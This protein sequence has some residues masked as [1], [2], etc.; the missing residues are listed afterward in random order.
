MRA[1]RLG[2][3]CSILL[4]LV[5]AAAVVRAEEPAGK[6]VRMAFV[7]TVSQASISPGYTIDFW[8]RL[9]ELGWVRGKN[10]IVEELWAEG[11]LERMPALMAQVVEHK[12]DLIVT[13]T[14]VGAIAA[15]NATQTI[16]I[17][18]VA[19]AD[20]V[21]AG[22]AASLSRP[23][24]NLTGLS[25]LSGEGIPGK[26]LELLRE[27]VPRMSVVAVLWN[28]DFPLI[29]LQV[30]HLEADA[31]AQGIKLRLIAVRTQ[32]ALQGAFALAKAHAQAV[33]VI[34]DPLMYSHRPQ[35]TSLAAHHH[36]PAIYTNPE[37]VPDG[38]L[39]A[40]GADLRV[41]YRRAAEYVDKILRGTKPADLPIEEPT[42]YSLVVNL[43]AAQALKLTIPESILLR[44]DEVI[45]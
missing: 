5:A 9:R 8:E 22:V 1:C 35:I 41:V 10:L 15:R 29:Q 42:K 14:E 38:G 11:Q 34:P 45:R 28:P 40:Y 4:I 24:G 17:V 20:P 36:L 30:K 16:P 44:A 19:L 33:L 13:G 39:M 26:C 18:V 2:I 37:F 21:G 31:L 7:A 3:R 27:A 23:G 25:R 32:Q 12:V 6:V 43:K